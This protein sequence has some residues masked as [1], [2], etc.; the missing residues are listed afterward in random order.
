MPIKPV[1]SRADAIAL[2]VEERGAE[3]VQL[4]EQQSVAMAAFTKQPMGTS[5]REIPLLETLPSAYWLDSGDQGDKTGAAAKDDAVKPTTSMKFG[6]KKLVAE[7]IAC[8]AVIPEAVLEDAHYD[9]W[10]FIR[11]RAA[12]AIGRAVDMAVFFGAAVDSKGTVGTAPASFGG[13]LFKMATDNDHV[14]Q[15]A[16]DPD[17]GEDFNLAM[18]LI[19]D[20]NYNPAAAFCGN[21]LKPK[22]RGLRDKNGNPI[23]APGLRNQPG[24]AS[25]DAVYGVPTRYSTNG[26]WDPTK[27]VAILADP[28]YCIIGVRQDIQAKFLDQATI[29]GVNL[30][31]TDQLALRIRARFGF[32]VLCPKGLGQSAKPFPAA[33]I[34]PK[35]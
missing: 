30:A 15:A 1:M 28:Q 29:Q 25:A 33:V 5:I 26:A 4:A 21:S 9:L 27:A 19:E 13:G 11:A 2:I 31:E 22:L 6:V 10:G 7:E 18:A 12:E 24:V 32:T 8:I 20:D 34:S 35:A 14:H 23:Y 16:E 3:V 17:I